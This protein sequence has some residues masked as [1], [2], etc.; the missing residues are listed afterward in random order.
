MFL[1]SY[2]A[3]KCKRKCFS[4]FWNFALWLWKSFENIVKGICTNPAQYTFLISY[5]FKHAEKYW[6]GSY[7]VCCYGS[8]YAKLLVSSSISLLSISLSL[9]IIDLFW[10]KIALETEEHVF[11]AGTYMQGARGHC[12]RNEKFYMVLPPQ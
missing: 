2:G 6:N 4:W 8:I 5:C 11:K 9:Q 7:D 3:S 10:A 12:P 1:Y